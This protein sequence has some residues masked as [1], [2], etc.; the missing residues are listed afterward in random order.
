MRRAILATL[1]VLIIT[2]M[3]HAAQTQPD[4]KRVKQI[5]SALLSHGYQPGKT[6]AETQSILRG[7]AGT[8]DW[9]V[10]RAPD[11]RVLILLG[12]G[13]DNSDI[14]VTTAPHNHLDTPQ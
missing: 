13:N 14:S 7:I 2:G 8:R 10:V 9:Q 11:A 3:L 4:A 6:W 1:A 5:Q 12:L